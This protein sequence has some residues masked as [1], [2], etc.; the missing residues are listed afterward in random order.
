MLEMLTG[1][2][3]NNTITIKID[4]FVIRLIYLIIIIL[5]GIF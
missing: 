4:Y 5:I 3:C 1:C 2:C